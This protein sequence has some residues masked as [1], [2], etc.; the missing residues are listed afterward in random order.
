MTLLSSSCGQAR[1]GAQRRNLVICGTSGEG[2]RVRAGWVCVEQ[3][4]P[5]PE[6]ARRQLWMRDLGRMA[7][8]DIQSPIASHR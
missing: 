8:P 6:E 7:A 3:E 5:Q 2:E 4:Q 1:G